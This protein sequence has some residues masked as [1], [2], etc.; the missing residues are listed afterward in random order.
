MYYVNANSTAETTAGATPPEPSHTSVLESKAENILKSFHEKTAGKDVFSTSNIVV[1]TAIF[2]TLLSVAYSVIKGKNIIRYGIAGAGIGVAT[3]LF[4]GSR[5]NKL[6]NQ[7]P[8]KDESK[9]TD[10]SSE[11]QGQTT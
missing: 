6:I 9:G 3:G 7:K 5:I 10:D 8:I 4:F 1:K 11:T 2:T